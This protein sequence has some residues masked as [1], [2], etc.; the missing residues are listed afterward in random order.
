MEK[1]IK[2]TQQLGTDIF[3]FGEAVHRADPTYWNKVK[4]NWEQ[5]FKQV[6][7]HL[8]VVAKVRGTGTMGDSVVNDVKE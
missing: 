4:D 6:V 3:G 8:N 5:E 1:T 7:P 2:K